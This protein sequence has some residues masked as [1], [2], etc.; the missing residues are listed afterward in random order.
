MGITITFLLV[1]YYISY[2]KSN[3][4]TVLKYEF[5]ELSASTKI[6]RIGPQIRK[7]LKD[8]I[9]AAKMTSKMQCSGCD[10]TGQCANTQYDR[11]CAISRT[12]II[13]KYPTISIRIS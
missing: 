13:I 1:F 8:Q 5:Q 12:H 10:V 11:L 6:L 7:L 4:N 9:P 3:L 2:F